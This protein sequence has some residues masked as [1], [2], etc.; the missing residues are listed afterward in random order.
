MARNNAKKKLQHS[1]LNYNINY[2]TRK[3][4]LIFERLLYSGTMHYGQK[5]SINGDNESSCKLL[6][7]V[8][9]DFNGHWLLVY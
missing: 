6:H 5:S 1:I 2:N 3:L 8:N 7:K 9:S 4:A